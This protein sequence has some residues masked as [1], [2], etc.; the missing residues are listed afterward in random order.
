MPRIE[1]LRDLLR[2]ELGV[3][4]FERETATTAG[5]VSARLMRQNPNR[6]AFILYNLSA[7]ILYINPITTPSSTNGI[8]LGPNGGFVSMY[9]REDFTLVGREWSI[10]ADVAGSAYYLLE[11]LLLKGEG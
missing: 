8:R 1:T 6:I 5:V 9:Y 3:E 2:E 10:I 11:I 7:N 4:T